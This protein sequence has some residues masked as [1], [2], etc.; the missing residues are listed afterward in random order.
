M[1]SA[2]IVRT[3]KPEDHLEVWRLLLQGHSENGIFPLAPQKVDWLVSRFLYPDTIQPED[4]GP[5]GVIGVIG[6]VGALEA[7]AVLVLG[8]FWYTQQR[9]IEELLVFVDPERRKSN[10]A[11]ALIHWM[12]HQ[13]QEVGLPLLSGV[14]SNHRT[15]AKCRLYQRMLPKIGE[16]FL[17]T[18]PGFVT[19]VSSAAAA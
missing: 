14:M 4:T 1:T 7:I 16:L 17:V 9:H 6:P 5:R 2:S 11:K 18:P 15:E 10:H 8:E 13:S 19:S 12:E 3:A